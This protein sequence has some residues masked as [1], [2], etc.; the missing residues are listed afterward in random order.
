[1]STVLDAYALI[2]LLV[3]EPAAEKVAGILRSGD[4][5]MTSVNYGEALDRLIRAR[6]MPEPRVRAALEPLLDGS[7]RRID[8][9]FSMAERA[10][11]LRAQHYHRERRPLS[12]ADCICIAAAGS[13][14][15]LATADEA[16]LAVADTEGV[17]TIPLD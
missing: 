5:A 11:R 8:V 17:G 10:V 14:G 1:M 12:L 2:A 4:A 13:D 3:D 16:M 6:R 15:K 9:G 7:L